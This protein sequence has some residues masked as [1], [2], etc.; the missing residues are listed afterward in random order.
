M[1]SASVE[2]LESYLEGWIQYTVVEASNSTPRRMKNGVPQ[3]GGLSPILWRSATN[4]LPEAGLQKLRRRGLEREQEAGE[5]R[6]VHDNEI[7][8]EELNL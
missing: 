4:D 6:I 8:E 5:G 3:G 1:S 7:R 2:W